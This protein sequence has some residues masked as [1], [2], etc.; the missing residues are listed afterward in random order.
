MSKVDPFGTWRYAQAVCFPAGAREESNDEGCAE[1]HEWPVPDAARSAQLSLTPRFR[2][3]SHPDAR[4]P[5]RAHSG[6]FHGIGAL[7]A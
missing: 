6:A 1:Q 4:E 3:T 5:A 7:N 2:R